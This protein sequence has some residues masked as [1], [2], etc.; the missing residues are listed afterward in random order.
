MSEHA[1]PVHRGPREGSTVRNPV[2][3]PLTF[4]AQ[5]AETGGSLT[6]FEIIAS[7]GEGPPLHVHA[8]ED[9]VLYVVEGELRFKLGDEVFP[10]STGTFVFVP[11]GVPHAWQTV[12]EAPARLLV[13]FTPAAPGMEKMFER[14]AEV[15]DET[16]PQ[17]AFGS[18]AKEAGME[19][20]GP[21]LAQSDPL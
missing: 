3:G 6:A 7:P 21:P 4:K 5:G 9:E 8:D 16:S 18:L 19:V 12:G 17:E 20:A 10:G 13:L 11:R 15:S 1:K 14:F 2:G